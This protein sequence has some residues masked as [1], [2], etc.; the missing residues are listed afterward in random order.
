MGSMLPYI[1]HFGSQRHFAASSL[2]GTARGLTEPP[3]PKSSSRIGRQTDRFFAWG[4]LFS[5]Y[6]CIHIFII[7]IYICLVIWLSVF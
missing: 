2:P 5:S 7:Y 3:M 1:A 6:G 4:Y